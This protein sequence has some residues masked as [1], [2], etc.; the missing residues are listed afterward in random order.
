MA[1]FRLAP[2]LT[3]AFDNM[4]TAPRSCREHVRGRVSADALLIASEL[5]SNVVR[6]T[7]SG[8]VMRVWL[9][10][11]VQRLEV[12]DYAGGSVATSAPSERGG[13]G[14]P[15]VAELS[16]RWGVEL[17]AGGKIVWAEIPVTR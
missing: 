1:S 15:I 4:P 17:T 2:D 10:D 16:T 9:G 8:G 13:R 6:H 3:F 11:R 5:V 7:R 14:I 12:E